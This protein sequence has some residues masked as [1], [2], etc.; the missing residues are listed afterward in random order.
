MASSSSIAST[1]IA[2]AKASTEASVKSG[3]LAEMLRLWHEH[4]RRVA[5][6]GMP[7]L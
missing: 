7:P 2:A 5:Q 6:F 3:L 4:N 1:R